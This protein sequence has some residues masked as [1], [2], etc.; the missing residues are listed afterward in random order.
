MLKLIGWFIKASIFAAVVLI[1][2]NYFKVGNKTISDQVKTQLSH[3]EQSN[4]ANVVDE[5]KDWA[6]HVTKDQSTGMAKKIKALRSGR[7]SENGKIRIAP[8][9]DKD[10]PNAVETAKEEIPSSER[11]K[12]R[13]LMRELNSSRETN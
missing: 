7:V 3:A 4:M 5:V 1:I 12:L 10:Q 8:V 2:G 6:H 13:A 9:I 11:Q